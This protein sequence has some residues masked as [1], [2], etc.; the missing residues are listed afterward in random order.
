MTK[1]E[2]MQN[3]QWLVEGKGRSQRNANQR[4]AEVVK[5]LYNDICNGATHSNCVDKLMNDGYEVGFKYS[6]CRA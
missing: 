5:H 3:N 2:I 4:V 6:K 1:E